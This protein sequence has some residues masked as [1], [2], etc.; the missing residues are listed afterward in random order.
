MNI[1]VWIFGLTDRFGTNIGNYRL[2]LD[3]S[4]IDPKGNAWAT[5]AELIYT[6]WVLP[7]AAAGMWVLEFITHPQKLFSPLEKAYTALLDP[8]FN[9]LPPISLAVLGMTVLLLYIT[10]ERRGSSLSIRHDAERIIVGF[11]LSVTAVVLARNPF[12]PMRAAMEFIQDVAAELSGGSS[13]DVGSPTVDSFLGPLTRIITYREELNDSCIAEWSQSLRDIGSSGPGCAPDASNVDASLA[14]SAFIGGWPVLAMTIFAG[15]AI[16]KLAI[17]L[18][19]ASWRLSC[20]WIAI[21]LAVFRRRQFD[22]IIAFLA[23]AV[24]H[25][26]MSILI[27]TLALIGP[28]T[29]MAITSSVAGNEGGG[30]VAMARFFLSIVL[31]FFAYCFMI[32]ALLWMTKKTGRI[33]KI[34]RIHGSDTMRDHYA[35]RSPQK[36]VFSGKDDMGDEDIY[37]VPWS[38]KLTKSGWNMSPEERKKAG[39]V[40]LG[41]PRTKGAAGGSGSGSSDNDKPTSGYGSSQDGHMNDEMRTQ[42]FPAQAADS[43][44][45]DPSDKKTQDQEKTQ[46]PQPRS[47]V[48]GAKDKAKNAVTDNR[49]TRTVGKAVGGAKKVAKPVLNKDGSV[50]T[51]LTQAATN[52]G[53]SMATGLAGKSLLR[54]KQSDFVNTENAGSPNAPAPGMEGSALVGRAPVMPPRSLRPDGTPVEPAAAGQGDS[55]S[56]GTLGQLVND[57]PATQPAP[58]H[59]QGA[60]TSGQDTTTPSGQGKAAQSAP[61]RGKHA[62]NDDQPATGSGQGHKPLGGLSSDRSASSTP[63]P[64]AA[65]G[66]RPGMSAAPS[67][68]PARDDAAGQ[69]RGDETPVHENESDRSRDERPYQRYGMTEIEQD[70][71]FLKGEAQKKPALTKRPAPRKN[72]KARTPVAPVPAPKANVYSQSVPDA[73]YAARRATTVSDSRALSNALGH[74]DR[75][76]VPSSDP[77]NTL[78]FDVVGGKNTATPLINKGLGR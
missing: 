57:Q 36:V 73:T 71:K 13:G 4:F 70:Q 68:M 77:A 58:R 51:S 52:V 8:V 25:A 60:E 26:I 3:P 20:A 14:F 21:I 62:K 44:V 63:R 35:T 47:G 64:D 11:L 5:F 65:T 15:I 34:L 40:S 6:W 1:V 2:L 9:I 75:T 18:F 74:G 29:A 53:R 46:P 23:P 59:A 66:T 27:M 12:G 32:Y 17:H 49:A 45:I 54:K 48:R 43:S 19:H 78:L 50:P 61:R 72:I 16:F 41:K 30:L 31:L 24:A 10:F 22:G 76:P 33:S 56:S 37:N 67:P 7:G 38:R 39:P 55:S 42:K 69:S 28:I